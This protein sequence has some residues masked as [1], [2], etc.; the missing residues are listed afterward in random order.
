LSNTEVSAR[1][2]SA[3]S[4]AGQFVDPKIEDFVGSAMMWR[5]AVFSLRFT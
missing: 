3:L 4:L 2:Q 1:R 5:I